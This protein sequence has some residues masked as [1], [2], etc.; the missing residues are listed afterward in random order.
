MLKSLPFEGTIKV[1]NKGVDVAVITDGIN[2]HTAMAASRP[3]VVTGISTAVLEVTELEPFDTRTFQYY[4]DLINKFV[5][6]NEEMAVA[7]KPYLNEDTI[8][9]TLDS[10]SEETIIAAVRKLNQ[11]T[12]SHLERRE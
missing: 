10:C 3:L 1:V 8:S 7:A 12:S 2:S 11:M 9:Y 5:F 4:V 6:V